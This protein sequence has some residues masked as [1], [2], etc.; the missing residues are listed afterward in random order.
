MERLLQQPHHDDLPL[1]PSGDGA[2]VSGA[3]RTTGRTLAPADLSAPCL[4]LDVDVVDGLP[5]L[6]PPALGEARCAWV[7][8]HLRTEPL[9]T[10]IVEIP[11]RARGSAELARI[12]WDE[13]G[14]AIEAR[15]RPG[16]VC[17]GADG[18]L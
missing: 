2:I 8:V 13:L 15:T 16:E 10:V 5:A 7:L 9:G 17:W 14:P 12:V 1:P 3:V 4:V 6:P 18:S 11:R